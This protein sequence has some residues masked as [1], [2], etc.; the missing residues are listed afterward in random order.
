M[1]LE[2]MVWSR[3][4][5]SCLR[6]RT[7]FQG[8]VR[9]S[10]ISSPAWTRSSCLRSPRVSLFRWTEV[11]HEQPPPVKVWGDKYARALSAPEY[12]MTLFKNVMPLYGGCQLVLRYCQ[13]S[14]IGV[15]EDPSAG[16]LLVPQEFT[17]FQ[18]RKACSWRR[19]KS[20]NSK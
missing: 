4:P 16:G 10:N 15:K 2:Y 3:G 19:S 6:A 13:R 1:S 17:G 5:W 14:T 7:V 20:E 18:P 8:D 11:V 9:L 12:S